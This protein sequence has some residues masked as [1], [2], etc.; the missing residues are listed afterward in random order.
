MAAFCENCGAQVSGGF[1][2]KCGARVGQPAMAYTP[3]IA[4]APAYTPPMAAA[5]PVAASGGSGLKIVLIVVGVLFFFGVLGIAGL[6]L[7][8]RSLIRRAEI[9]TLGSASIDRDAAARS[10]NSGGMF[11]SIRNSV[12]GHR[13]GCALLPA[14]EVASILGV[15]VGKTDGQPTAAEKGEHCDYFLKAGTSDAYA[16]KFKESLK[17][18]QAKGNQPTADSLRQLNEQSRKSGVES[19]IK[20]MIRAGGAVA[21]DGSQPFFSFIVEREGG[22]E[23]FGVMERTN[24]AGRVL[25]NG[26]EMVEKLSGVGDRAFL[27]PLDSAL[28]VLKADTCV[29]FNLTQV[30][31]GKEK[32]AEL[33]RRVVSRL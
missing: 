30:P 20:N 28:I 31:D 18:A 33:A 21:N 32:G 9:A 17:A 14:D 22:R 23:T 1:C 12:A 10:S 16:E 7:T 24:S 29:T 5:P 3:P 15:E 11:S 26:A 25:L 4:A 27:T 8:G 6:Y 2:G 13:D 19:V